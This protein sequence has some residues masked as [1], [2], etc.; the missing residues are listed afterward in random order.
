MTVALTQ[1]LRVRTQLRY[2]QPK[3]LCK[4]ATATLRPHQ[5]VL[6]LVTVVV[7]WEL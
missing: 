4:G 2:L 1:P 3:D 5:M 7:S 6:Y